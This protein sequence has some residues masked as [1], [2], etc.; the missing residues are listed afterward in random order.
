MTGLPSLAPLAAAAAG[1]LWFWGM[2]IYHYRRLAP[3]MKSVRLWWGVV[4]FWLWKLVGDLIFRLDHHGSRIKNF[5]WQRPTRFWK[6][7]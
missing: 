5:T 6:W 7:H 3:R 1:L 4:P 2:E